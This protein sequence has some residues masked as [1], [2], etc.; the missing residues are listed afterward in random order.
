MPVHDIVV[1]P[2]DREL[3]V[4]THGR[5]IFI[6]DAAPLQ[7][8]TAT[9]LARP[10]FLFDVKPALEFKY[11]T[12][13]KPAPKEYF[14]ANPEYGAALYVYLKDKPTGDVTL[15][16][17]DPEGKPV[18]QSERGDGSRLAARAVGPQEDAG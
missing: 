5:G 10:A 1:H 2:R 17:R 18:A 7:Q 15:T 16:V 13:D 12:K 14:G 4:G 3:V 11:R 9:V 8:M 6:L